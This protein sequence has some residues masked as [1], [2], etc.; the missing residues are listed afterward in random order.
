MSPARFWQVQIAD[1]GAIGDSSLAQSCQGQR[2]H[3]RPFYQRES[4]NKQNWPTPEDHVH[5]LTETG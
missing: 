3:P 1:D 5:C 4:P 2:G